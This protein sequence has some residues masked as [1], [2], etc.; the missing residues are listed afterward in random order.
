LILDKR[1][2]TQKNR[3]TAKHAKSAKADYAKLAD[4]LYAIQLDSALALLASLAVCPYS[5]GE[6]VSCENR[7]IF[8]SASHFLAFDLGAESGRAILA[9]LDGQKLSLAEKHRFANPNGKML[10][11][12]HWNLLSQWEEL[13]TGLRNASA[14][15]ATPL[16]G[17]G[18][19][20]WGVD[21]GLLTDAGDI[22]ANPVMYRDPRNEPM[23]ELTF[24]KI[25]RE[26]L[27]EATGI[28]FMVFNTLFQLQAMK[29]HSPKLLEAA[30]T[31]LFMPDLFNYLLCGSRKSELS[32]ASTSQMYDPRQKRWATEILQ[33][34]DL[35]T[36]ILPP[37]VPSGTVMGDLLPD[38]AAECGAKPAPVIAPGCHDTA[39]AVAA[40]PAETGEDYCYIS[41]GTWSLMGVELP[42]ANVS[43]KALQ[44]NYTNEI[45]VGEM[46]VGP[47]VRFLKNIMGLWLVQECRRY[48]QKHGND[49]GYEELTQMAGRAQPFGPLIDPAHAPFLFPG[50]MIPKIDRFCDETKQRR[51]GT[52]GEYVRTCLESLALTYR[53]TLEGLQDILGRKISVIHIVGGGTKNELLNQMTADACA[54]PVIAGPIEATAIGNVLVQAEAVG[55]VK[56]LADARA[57][58]RENFDVKRYE[59]KDTAKWDAA[60]Q[61]YMQIVDKD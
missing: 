27:F 35:P 39:S 61:R 12:L 47:C 22:L 36:R 23:L 44:Y 34:L 55:V 3:R 42:D 13:K 54:R 43:A 24:A 9:T 41:S 49:H 31:M 2:Q 20:T 8:M 52:R 46:G 1:S 48:W 10:G 50:D 11:R 51:P 56:S 53:R 7:R 6:S 29:H 33:T 30:A 32:I 58:V 5:F 18:V 19:D 28:Q 25:P 26:K 21:F 14:D 37:I 45:G 40:V 59:P 38:V 57:I 60:Y 16:A 17:I 4:Y 15:L